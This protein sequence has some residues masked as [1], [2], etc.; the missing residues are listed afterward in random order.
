MTILS[1]TYTKA[2]GKISSRVAIPLVIPSD[3]YFTIDVSDLDIEDQALVA[4]EIE[5][6]DLDKQARINEIMEK[7]DIRT[8][9]RSF[10]PSRMTDIVEE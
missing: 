5:Q 4:S 2:D 1:F 8:N 9:F 6:A 3:N 10:I 7:Y